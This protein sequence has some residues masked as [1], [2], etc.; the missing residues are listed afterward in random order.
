MKMIKSFLV[1]FFAFSVSFLNA[2]EQQ[3]YSLTLDEAINYALQHNKTLLNARGE[4]ASS[5]EAVREARSSGLPQISG[6]LDF[7]TYF[8]YEMKFEFGSSSEGT[9]IPDITKPPFDDGDRAVLGMMGSMF[10]SEPIIMDNQMSGAVS[11]SQ[12]IFS[13][14]YWAGIEMA[15]IARNL[16]NQNVVRTE[17]DVKEGVI[18][19]YYMILLTEQN[20]RI[21]ND[22]INNLNETLQHTENMYKTG[23]ME[24]TDVDQLRI[25]VSQLKNAQKSVERTIQMGYN[26]L[27][28][29]LGA[30]PSAKI[31]LN[32]NL[33]TIL[34]EIDPASALDYSFD[35]TNNINYSLTES[36][37]KLGEKQVGLQNWAYAPTVAG[38]YSYTKKIITTGFDMTPEH[39][40]GFNASIPIFSGGARRARVNQ[41]KVALDIAKRNQEMVREQLETQK[42]QMLYNYQ[43][44]LENYQTQKENVEVAGRVY[45][46]IQNKYQQGMMSS[47]DLTQASNN[48]LNAESNYM[49][50][51]LTLL[52]AQTSLNK[53]YNKI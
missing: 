25:T 33:E 30:D 15:K 3:T 29:Q 39:L 40:A 45:K 23:L 17:Q 34:N 21:L 18:N 11:V 47:L 13:G 52:Q 37:V 16:A 22:N 46:N 20:L 51:V 32:A 42:N 28:F 53:L 2:Q 10:S 7:M 14:Q 38:F 43:N 26:M 24:I 48:L 8:N 4:V 50:A 9:P 44:A 36:M 6:S 49:S 31:T 12:L 27:R 19:S 35:V 5:T 41:A 1:L